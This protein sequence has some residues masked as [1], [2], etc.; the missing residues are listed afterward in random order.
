MRRRTL[1]LGGVVLGGAALVLFCCTD[2]A[3]RPAEHPA[4]P[5]APSGEPAPGPANSSE[6][7]PATATATAPSASAPAPE[8]SASASTRPGARIAD[9]VRSADP[10]DLELLGSIE[11]EL[12]RNP[13]PE[14]HALLSSR[15][16]GADRAELTLQIQALPDLKLR[17]LA[18]RWL[19]K[20]MP[21]P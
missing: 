4:P 17:V 2:T 10:H 11:R 9:A 21:K 14:V 18:L 12:H 19:D 20:V 16:K 5:V 8:P 15:Q 6:A 3:H 13:P 1:A 7:T